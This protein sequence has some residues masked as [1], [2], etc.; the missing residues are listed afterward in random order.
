MPLRTYVKHCF[1]P[2][3][4]VLLKNIII[5][6]LAH[7]RPTLAQSNEINKENNL[8]TEE[9]NTVMGLIIS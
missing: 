5:S 2:G 4:Q 9:K 3:A 1:I 7:S 6:I 8:K